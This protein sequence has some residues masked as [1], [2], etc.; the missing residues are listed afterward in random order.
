MHAET[1]K[2]RNT[3]R[4]VYLHMHGGSWLLGGAKWQN[5]IR[6]LSLAE[7]LDMA[8]VSVD[9][10]LAPEHQLPAILDDCVAA[11]AWLV[12]NSQSE[13]GTQRLIIGGESAGG[14]L[15]AST[16]LRLRAALGLS[17]TAP[18]PFCA[19]NLVYGVYDLSGTPSMRHYTKKLVFNWGELQQALEILLPPDTDRSSPEVSPLYAP[20]EALRHMPPALFSCGTDDALIDDTVFMASRYAALAEGGAEVA[21]WPGGAHGVGHFGPHATTALGR[22]AHER[23]EAF[24]AKHLA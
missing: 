8:I 24:M 14:H 2:R 6:L 3:V 11:A 19:A 16:M 18:F 20:P 1:Q 17:S 5:D 15:C 7:K 4:G 9:Y 23:I 10:R 12:E 13:F 21:L 22:A